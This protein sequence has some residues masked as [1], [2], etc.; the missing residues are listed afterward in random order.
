MKQIEVVPDRPDEP[1]LMTPGEVTAL[2]RVSYSS[3]ARWADAG[4]VAVIR[5]P[6]GHRRYLR[7]E[8]AALMRGESL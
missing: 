4:K 3:L 1:D 7:T 8:I 5:T 6:G 2:F